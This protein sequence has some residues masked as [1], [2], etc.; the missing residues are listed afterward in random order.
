MNYTAH[1]DDLKRKIGDLVGDFAKKK[2]KKK[3]KKNGD[4]NGWRALLAAI[5]DTLQW[6]SS[7][8]M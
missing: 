7:Y 4:Q 5:V 3:K 6:S 1:F 2:K 8:I